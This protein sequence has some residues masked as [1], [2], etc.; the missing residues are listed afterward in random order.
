[1]EAGE[2]GGRI[3]DG[4]LLR[5][6]F[7]WISSAI[8]ALTAVPLRCLLDF[9]PLSSAIGEGMDESSSWI[10]VPEGSGLIFLVEAG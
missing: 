4:S 8:P 3:A 2:G 9:R 1:M 10:D 7:A 5:L 6:L